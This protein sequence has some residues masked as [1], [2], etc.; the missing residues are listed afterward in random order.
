MISSLPIVLWLAALAAL[1]ASALT[2]LKTR[3][4]P[5]GLVLFVLTMGMAL[6]QLSGRGTL[7]LSLPIAGL[8]YVV[9]AM[10]THLDV[11]GGGDTKMISAVTVLVPPSVVPAE[12]VAIAL[13]G[14]V[15]SLFYLG[16]GWLARR[17]GGAGLA[18]GAPYPGASDF[19]HL[20]RIEVGRMIA[21]EP[22]P[23]GVAIFGGVVSL[24]TIGVL[25]CISATSCSPSA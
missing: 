11:L 23:Y 22:M 18:A 17:N 14:G 3:T 21:N 13:A 16:A 6:Q 25:S 15:L 19:D 5:N 10:L 7:W 8:V 24:I 2:D 9:G 4:I 12:L 20:V 1:F